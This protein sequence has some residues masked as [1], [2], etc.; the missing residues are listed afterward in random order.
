MW[1]EAAESKY[2]GEDLKKGLPESPN[3]ENIE[4]IIFSIILGVT[5]ALCVRCAVSTE[6]PALK[7]PTKIV[8][9]VPDLLGGRIGHSLMIWPSFLQ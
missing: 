2:Q 5:E 6:L 8:Y 3:E 4:M 1:W 7:E 9:V